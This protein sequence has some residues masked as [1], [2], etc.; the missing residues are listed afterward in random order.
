MGDAYLPLADSE[1]ASALFYN[2]ASLAKIRSFKPEFMNLKIHANSV[3]GSSFGLNAN[4]VKFPSLSGFSSVLQEEANSGKW[5]GGGLDFAPTFSF[6]GL[7]VG[8][9]VSSDF[10]AKSENGSIRYKS[11]YQVIPAIGGALR[12]A[13]GILRVGYTL[14]WVNQASGDV[15]VSAGSSSLG[16][17]EGIQKGSGISHNLG[18]ALTLPYTYLPAFNLVA[19]NVLGLRYSLRS[20]VPLAQNSSGTLG[21]EPMSLDAAVSISPRLGSGAFMN[22]ILQYKDIQNTCGMP[23]LGRLSLGT[24]LSFRDTFFLRGG[25]G[26][27][28]PSA[29]FGF[30]HKRAELSFGWHSEEIG[31]GYRDQRDMRY[32]FNYQ[33]RAF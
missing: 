30:R 33:V 27:G 3:L 10:L 19:R 12:F 29:G 15:T 31:A 5:F 17:N 9:L 24:E 11:K 6:R 2:P 32:S 21:D 18:V 4:P 20:L 13:S 25:W 22:L 8:V 26:S 7:G 1:G 16:Y 23:V 14:Q 28:Y